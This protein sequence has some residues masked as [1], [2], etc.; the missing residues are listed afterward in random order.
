MARDRARAGANRQPASYVLPAPAAGRPGQRTASPSGRNRGATRRPDARFARSRRA[1]GTS[2]SAST[3]RSRAGG[4]GRP[5]TPA[6][7]CTARSRTGREA[8]VT[9]ATPAPPSG[10]N[11][12][13]APATA[14]R[15]R[16]LARRT[17]STGAPGSGPYR[18]AGGTDEPRDARTHASPARVGRREGLAPPVRRDRERA[19]PSA[20][21][22]QRPQTPPARAPDG[23][24]GSPEQR[25]H[26]R[27]GGT[28]RPR[29]PPPADTAR[30]RAGRAA[31]A[32]RGS[33]PRAP[34][35]PSV[36]PAAPSRSR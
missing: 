25:P 11:R 3:P 5:L 12:R 22:S 6:L 18:R 15:H 16:P 35:R 21:A 2:R 8:R 23:R 29:Q 32:P 17:G 20:R 30:S 13:A 36:R 10:R 19:E 1:L 14:R 24:H 27:T 4:R 34:R 31:R 26:R 33:G 9:R 7:A 28:G